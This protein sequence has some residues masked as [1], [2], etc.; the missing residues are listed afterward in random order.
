[1]TPSNTRADARSAATRIADDLTYPPDPWPLPAGVDPR[2]GR[3]QSLAGGA[4]GVALLHAERARTGHGPEDTLHHW[5]TYITSEPLSAGGNADLYYGTPAFGYVLHLAAGISGRYQR[6]RAAVDAI[7]Q[8]R[9]RQ[10]LNAA[11]ARISRGEPLPMHEFDLINGLSG[12]A[13]YHLRLHP[14]VPITQELITYLIRLTKAP[15]NGA[16]DKPPWWMDSGL[17]GDPSDEFPGGHGNL[18]TAHGITAV[19]A[20]LAR[21]ALDG[22]TTPG[23][24]DAIGRIC[25]WLD[26]WRQPGPDAAWWPGYLTVAN[27]ASGTVHQHQRPR[28]SW[29]YGIAG[30]ARAQQL[31]GLA[32]G[33]THRIQDIQT[34][35]LNTVRSPQQRSQLPEVGLCHGMA[36]LLLCTTR[37]AQN[38]TSPEL[39][40]ELPGLAEQLMERLGGSASPHLMDGAVGAALALHTLDADTTSCSGWD[41][42]LLLA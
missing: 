19:L 34:A 8:R 38:A 41:A 35:L 15:E 13:A 10:R 11:Q 1:M 42:F 33:D 16:A 12:D 30:M 4:L 25:T 9:T 14:E 39:A 24:I 32:L 29:C 18:G 23:L 20:L 37:V 26:H 22:H 3:R 36:G 40:A 21:A 28:P 31:A 27:I 7:V 6:A 2:Q 5:L 17:N